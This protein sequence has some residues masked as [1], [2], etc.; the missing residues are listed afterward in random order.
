MK[1]ILIKAAEKK[2]VAVNMKPD[3]NRSLEDLRALIG[4]E[5]V[6]P[7]V[8]G[9]GVTIWVDEEGRLKQPAAGFLLS[10][11]PC[12]FVG[13]GVL[14]GGDA[15][16][17]KPCYVPAN[18]VAMGVKWLAPDQVPPPGP[19]QFVVCHHNQTKEKNSHE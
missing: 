13:N 19:P 12:I 3:P 18:I 15:D 1:A 17:V 6:Q 16:Q 2:V 10:G 4:C 14:L 8:V 11:V 5:W 9:D 7:V